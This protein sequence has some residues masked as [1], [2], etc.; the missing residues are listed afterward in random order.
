ML[1]HMDCPCN[2]IE[3]CMLI[4]CMDY[5]SDMGWDVHIY[6]NV[7][8]SVTGNIGSAVDPILYVKQPC[9]I[10]STWFFLEG[11]ENWSTSVWFWNV[12]CWVTMG[13]WKWPKKGLYNCRKIVQLHFNF[14]TAKN[15]QLQFHFTTAKSYIGPL[16]H[17]ARLVGELSLTSTLG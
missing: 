16:P 11:K 8:E 17:S 2:A 3:L 14:T 10:G 5:Y 15:V 6:L 9:R 12:H 7:G 4:G 13:A 1:F